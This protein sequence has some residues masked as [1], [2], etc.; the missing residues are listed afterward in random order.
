MVIYV[1]S[2]TNSLQ[3]IKPQYLEMEDTWDIQSR[4]SAIEYFC[5]PGWLAGCQSHAMLVIPIM[6]IT[7]KTHSCK[8]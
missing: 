2:E 4:L 6:G 3:Y 7:N 5:V 8:S 1:G